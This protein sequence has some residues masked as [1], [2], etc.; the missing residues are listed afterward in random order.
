[1]A[2]VLPSIRVYLDEETHE[3][4]GELADVMGTSRSAVVRE[5][6]EDAAPMFRVLVDAGRALQG[7]GEVRRAAFGGLVDELTVRHTKV[8]GVLGEVVS[9]VREAAADDSP[10]LTGESE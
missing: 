6:L 1:M 2:S 4:V 3:V 5:L 9:L 7:A 10:P 8:Q